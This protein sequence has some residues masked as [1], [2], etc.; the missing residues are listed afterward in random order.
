M[1]IK[2]YQFAEFHLGQLKNVDMTG[3]KKIELGC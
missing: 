1:L 2:L 3:H